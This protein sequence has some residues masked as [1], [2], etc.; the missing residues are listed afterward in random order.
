MIVGALKKSDTDDSRGL[1]AWPFGTAV[2]YNRRH[3]DILGIFDAK[4]IAVSWAFET[5]E[6]T[7]L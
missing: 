5:H 2:L 3:P 6:P 1:S 7:S 4:R